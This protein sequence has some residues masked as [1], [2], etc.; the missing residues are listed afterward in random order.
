MSRQ[1]KLFI[2][3]VGENTGATNLS[4]VRVSK[5]VRVAEFFAGIGLVRLAAQN[6]GGKV[7]WANDIEPLKQRIYEE[8]FGCS[9]FHLGDICKVVGSDIPQVEVA[10]ASFPCTDLSLAGARRGLAGSAS[11]LFWEF[12]RI[13]EEMGTA[14]PPV[15]LLENVPGLATSHGGDDLVAAIRRLGE[16]GYWCDVIQADARWFVPQSRPRLFIVGLREQISEIPVRPDTVHPRHLVDFMQSNPSLRVQALPFGQPAMP[17]L[18]IDTIVEKFRA[19]SSVWWD[20]ERAGLFESSLSALQ[21]Q[22]VERL[23]ERRALTWRTAYRRT[24]D[25]VPQWEIRADELAGCLR[26]ARGGSSKQAVVQVGRGTMKVRWMTPR[27]YGRLQGVPDTFS[28]ESVS[29]NQALFGFGDAVCVPT[30][31]WVFGH[32]IEMI[33]STLAK[34]S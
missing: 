3:I 8:N 12:T 27:E 22:R 31:A 13:L 20:A 30:V 2:D 19:K 6:V 21:L 29:P 32:V 15:V 4:T 34:A 9:D 1:Q 24:R 17:Q 23:K 14:K 16:L 7:V 10:T 5:P 28:F 33:S 11:G 18:S 25:G 26:T